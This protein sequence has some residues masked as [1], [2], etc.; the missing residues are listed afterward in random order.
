MDCEVFIHV[1]IPKTGS[2]FLQKKVFKNINHLDYYKS[3]PY[4]AERVDSIPNMSFSDD[5]DDLSNE[6]TEYI[7]KNSIKKLLISNESLFGHPLHNFLNHELI[8]RN[9]K[10]IFPNA[11]ILVVIR[12]QIDFFESLYK[13]VV[14]LGYPLNKS[15]FFRI[16][17]GQFQKWGYNKG[18]NISIFSL[19]YYKLMEVYE[20]YYSKDVISLLPYEKLRELP[21]EFK[22][23]LEEWICEE[24]NDW[25]IT[26]KVNI[27]LNE[28]QFLVL[29][30]LNPFFKSSIS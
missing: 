23:S 11:K 27:G 19:D 24:I 20:K 10:V 16:E 22:H 3:H 4:L 30:V 6:I 14:Y 21:N 29:K 5:I 18:V 26:S 9:L 7:S 13:Y 25:P 1:G 17:D 2:T 28:V 15:Q 12:N 8:I